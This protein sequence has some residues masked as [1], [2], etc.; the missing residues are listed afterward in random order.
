MLLG[1][2]HTFLGSAPDGWSM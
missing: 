1:V 2:Q